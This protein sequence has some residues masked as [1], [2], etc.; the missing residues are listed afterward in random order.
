MS[1]VG[2][3]GLFYERDLVLIGRELGW[4]RESYLYSF[5]RGRRAHRCVKKLLALLRVKQIRIGFD[6]GLAHLFE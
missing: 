6:K 1:C 4:Q 2:P 3:V 5:Y